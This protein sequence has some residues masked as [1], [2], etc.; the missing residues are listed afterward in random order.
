MQDERVCSLNQARFATGGKGSVA[1]RIEQR[2]SQPLCSLCF[3]WYCFY[4][5]SRSTVFTGKSQCASRI[6]NRRCSSRLYVSWSGESC[7]LIASSSKGSFATV[8]FL[9]TIVT[10]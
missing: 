6:S 5:P 10:R 7:F 4:L 2:K 8:A 1:P 3:F 9:K